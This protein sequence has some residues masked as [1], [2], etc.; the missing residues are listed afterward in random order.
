[1]VIK[2]CKFCGVTLGVTWI[3]LYIYIY[4]YII[5]INRLTMQI[6]TNIEAQ[7]MPQQPLI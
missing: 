6:S 7:T 3:H 4:M 2:R 5:Y 1:M